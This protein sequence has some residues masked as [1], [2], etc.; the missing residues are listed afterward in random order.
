MTLQRILVRAIKFH[1]ER[2]ADIVL[3]T[4]KLSKRATDVAP[5]RN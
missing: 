5:R 2:L 1:L 4:R 3:R